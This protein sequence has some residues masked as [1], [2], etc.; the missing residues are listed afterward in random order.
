MPLTWPVGDAGHFRGVLDRRSGQFVR[1]QRTAGGATAA[2]EDHL[3][4][5]QAEAEEGAN[6]TRASE[7]AELL[8]ASGG[9]FELERFLNA[10]ATPGAVRVGRAQLRCAAAARPARRDRT[11]SHRAAGRRR[12]SA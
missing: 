5:S 3:P 9:E 7:E 8:G 4:P 2:G 6:W 11:T 10:T 1:Y 12:R